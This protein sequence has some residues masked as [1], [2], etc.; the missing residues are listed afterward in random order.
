MMEH[1]KAAVIEVLN[2]YGFALDAQ[3]W[4]LFDRV[5][6][7]A[8]RADFG[9]AGANW[10]D[11]ANFKR[12]FA[13]FHATLDNH[14]HTMMGQLPMATGSWCATTPRVAPRGSGPAGTMT[15]WF[16]ASAAG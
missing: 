15:S 14:Q 10:H 9:P 13:E 2:L 8:V 5:F 3:E 4:D 12:S 11:L 1:D 7:E 6:T 16:V